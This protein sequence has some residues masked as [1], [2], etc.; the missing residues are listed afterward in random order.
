M[1]RNAL[2]HLTPKERA[3]LEE[4]ITRLREKYRD[5]LVRVILFGSKVRGDFDAESD[6]DLMTVFKPTAR[7]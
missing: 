7:T 4:L 6:I 3:A 2:A 5:H 1:R